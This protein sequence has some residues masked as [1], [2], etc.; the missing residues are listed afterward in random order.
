MAT[1]SQAF[2][3]RQHHLLPEKSGSDRRHTHDP[4][5]SRAYA[6]RTGSHYPQPYF[7]PT[8]LNSI[9]PNIYLR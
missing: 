9:S 5:R 6:M 4:A 7:K 3:F 8:R 1:S 2:G